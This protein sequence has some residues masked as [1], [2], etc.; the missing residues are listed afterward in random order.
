MAH[1]LVRFSYA[2]LS[3][4]GMIRKPD[5]DLA[6]QASMMAESLGAKLLG[7]WFAFGEFDGVALMWRE[8]QLAAEALRR[9]SVRRA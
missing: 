9:T 7:Y 6:T 8:L 1:F 2:S 5:L 3:V 4:E